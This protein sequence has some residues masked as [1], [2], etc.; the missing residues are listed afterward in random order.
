MIQYSQESVCV[1]ESAL[2]RTTSTVIQTPD[3]VLV[4][5]PNWLP[6]E[7]AAIRRYVQQMAAGRPLYLLFTHSDY[8]HIIGYGAFPEAK[9]IASAAFAHNPQSAAIVQQIL[10]WDA[11]FY[12]ERPYPISYPTVDVVMH[13]DGQQVQI[14]ST[15]IQSWQAPGHTD[16]GLFT[17]VSWEE[18]VW[19]AGDYLSNIEFPFVYHSVAAYAA[20]LD[21]AAYLLA[22][23]EPSVLVPGHGDVARD[24]AE[25]HRRIVAAKRYVAELYEAVRADKA[26]PEDELWQRYAFRKGMEPYHR[27]NEALLRKELAGV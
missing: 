1:F 14:G 21:K 11:G 5:D 25:V 13:E 9:V 6:Q 20:T 8:D 23:Y 10:D 16:D 19:L 15:R 24:A 7:V 12:I 27:A 26:F 18:Q 2:Y 22:Q 3:L 17:I 4:V